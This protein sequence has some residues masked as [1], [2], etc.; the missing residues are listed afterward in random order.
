MY[1]AERYRYNAAECLVA[2][3]DPRQPDYRKLNFS[4]AALWLALAAAD[5]AVANLVASWDIPSPS[6]LAGMVRRVPTAYQKA[7]LSNFEQIV[8]R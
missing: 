4:M 7:K 6:K 8:A 3:Y 5:E 1:D 2:A